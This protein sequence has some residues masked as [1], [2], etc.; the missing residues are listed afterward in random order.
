MEKY[1]SF[2]GSVLYVAVML[3]I[4]AGWSM[5]RRHQFQQRV[6]REMQIKQATTPKGGPVGNLQEGIRWQ[7]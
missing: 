7:D 4:F 6:Q 3:G 2:L 1:K 5:Y